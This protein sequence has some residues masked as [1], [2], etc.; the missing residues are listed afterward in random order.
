MERRRRFE[1]IPLADV[2][3]RAVEVDSW[4]QIRDI[5][6]QD[7]LNVVGEGAKPNSVRHLPMRHGHQPANGPA[8]M[9]N[10]SQTKTPMATKATPPR[11][12]VVDDEPSITDTL[13]AILRTAGYDAAPSYDAETALS[14]CESLRPDL[15]IT[16]VVMPG[17]NGIEMAI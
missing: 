2:L 11:V 12:L 8:K 15:L 17:M 10:E 3:K 7:E 9:S 14:L 6:T 1:T 5:T 13:V 4:G 16:D